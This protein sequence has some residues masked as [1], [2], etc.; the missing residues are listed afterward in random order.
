MVPITMLHMYSTV[1]A[2][3]MHILLMLIYHID[4]G[5][6]IVCLFKVLME[7]RVC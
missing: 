6:M 2:T 3:F 7:H 5:L 4:D 1:N